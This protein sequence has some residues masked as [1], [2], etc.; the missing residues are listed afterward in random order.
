MTDVEHY[1]VA[2]PGVRGHAITGKVAAQDR[3]WAKVKAHRAKLKSASIKGKTLL[4]DKEVSSRLSVLQGKAAQEMQDEIAKV[5]PLDQQIGLA[6]I[7]ENEVQAIEIFDSPETYRHFHSHLM[8]RFAY[9]IAT[10][11]P[12]TPKKVASLR[13]RMLNEVRRLSQ[14]LDIEEGKGTAQ[15]KGKILGTLQNKDKRLVHLCLE[16]I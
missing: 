6:V 15:Q 9:E 14:H 3:V 8:G 4:D 2:S 1:S 7:S 12:T 10:P 13:A 16:K 11:K 5:Q